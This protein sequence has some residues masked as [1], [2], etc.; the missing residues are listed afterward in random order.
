M[1]RMLFSLMAMVCVLTL[2]AQSIY[3]FKVKDD[4]GQE[5]SLSDYKGVA[6]SWSADRLAIPAFSISENSS[7]FL[8]MTYFR[9]LPSISASRWKLPL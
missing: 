4:V 9:S 2:S 6:L 8:P 7:L 5:V 1:K 3:D